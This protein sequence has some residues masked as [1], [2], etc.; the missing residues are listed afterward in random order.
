MPNF[1]NQNH[2]DSVKVIFWQKRWLNFR[3]IL[4]ISESVA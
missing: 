3:H 1:S 2:Q 4:Q